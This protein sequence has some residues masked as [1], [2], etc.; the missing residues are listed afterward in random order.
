MTRASGLDRRAVLGAGVGLA[1]LMSGCAGPDHLRVERLS[2]DDLRGWRDAD[3]DAALAIFAATAS[4]AKAHPA[5]GVEKSDWTKIAT[6]CPARAAFETQ[7][8]P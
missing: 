3:H 2:F 7:F 4:I 5:L 1:A 6:A 8:S